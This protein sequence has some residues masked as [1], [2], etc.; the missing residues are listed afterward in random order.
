MG[1]VFE[2]LLRDKLQECGWPLSVKDKVFS[3]V[4]TVVCRAPV[5]VEIGGVT[6]QWCNIAIC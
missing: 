4:L 1:G 5:S 2:P 3:E 6:T